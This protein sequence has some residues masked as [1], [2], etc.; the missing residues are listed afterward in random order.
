MGPLA[1]VTFPRITTKDIWVA[2]NN[3]RPDAVK[4]KVTDPATS[5]L[6]TASSSFLKFGRVGFTPPAPVWLLI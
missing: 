6:A 2:G 4:L 3:G 1:K 5:R